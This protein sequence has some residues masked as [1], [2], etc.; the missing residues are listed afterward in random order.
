[1]TKASVLRPP[2]PSSKDKDITWQELQ[3][4]SPALALAKLIDSTPGRVLVVTADANQAYRLE[5]E[6]KF[7]AG[8]HTEYHD[9]ITLFPD[10]ETLP[11][12]SFSPHQDYL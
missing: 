5:E 2:F 1:M 6:V 9:D 4:S 3:G 7:F 12:D 11:Y 10:W 8:E